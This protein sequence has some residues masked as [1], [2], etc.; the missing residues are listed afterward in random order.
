[1]L[2]N[3]RVDTVTVTP[4][5][6]NY[7]PVSGLVPGAESDSLAYLVT[8]YPGPGT[9]LSRA[10]VDSVIREA[11]RLWQPAGQAITKKI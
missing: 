6:Q 7:A 8:Q 3:S 2:D 1:M 11:A 4:R 9:R 10:E 5:D